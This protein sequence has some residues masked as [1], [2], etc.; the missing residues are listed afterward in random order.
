MRHF[1]AFYF[2]NLSEAIAVLDIV[3]GFSNFG[4]DYN[5]YDRTLLNVR[6]TNEETTL[7]WC[8]VAGDLSL[9]TEEITSG[10]WKQYKKLFFE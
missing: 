9:A 6:L 3:E 2:S 7:A 10:S 8:Y 1:V 4:A 5:E